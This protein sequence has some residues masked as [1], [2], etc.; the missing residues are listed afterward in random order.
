MVRFDLEILLLHH[1]PS[2]WETHLLSLIVA[3]HSA[4]HCIPEGGKVF[5]HDVSVKPPKVKK[6]SKQAK[7]RISIPIDL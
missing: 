7:T 5:L 6:V 2:Q 4:I 3:A 1:S